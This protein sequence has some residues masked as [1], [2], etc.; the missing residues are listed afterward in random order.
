[1]NRWIAQ[2]GLA[3]SFVSLILLA[4]GAGSAAAQTV[5]VA[6]DAFLDVRRP[7]GTEAVGGNTGAIPTKYDSTTGGGGVRIGA[8]VAPRWTVELGFDPGATASNQ[9]STPVAIPLVT[10]GILLLPSYSAT[11]SNRVTAT[12]V[13]LGYHPETRGRLRPGFRA[14][15]TFLH[16]STS[17]KETIT[18]TIQ[19]NPTFPGVIPIPT[20][21]PTNTQVTSVTNEVAATV[22]GEV[23]IAVNARSAVVPELRAFG[24]GTHF[25]IRPGV[26]F[27]WTF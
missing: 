20:P 11:S 16:T 25:V 24:A 21:E 17:T 6:G 9:L 26:A 19:N 8:F 15:L 22:G 14:G 3:V 18:Y 2:T 5:C 12:S 7:S 23:A 1:M 27:R 4:S 13:L 10:T